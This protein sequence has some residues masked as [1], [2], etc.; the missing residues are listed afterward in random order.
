MFYIMDGHIITQ[1]IDLVTDIVYFIV[2][3]NCSI[4]MI[5]LSMYMYIVFL[6]A[7]WVIISMLP[8]T[9]AVHVAETML[10]HLLPAI[11]LKPCL[12]CLACH[13]RP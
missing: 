10:L 8:V 1:H 2:A 6:H 9:I 5:L 11:C 12:R 13:D 3:V 7:S 4:V